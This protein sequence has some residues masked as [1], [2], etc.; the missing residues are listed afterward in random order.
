MDVSYNNKTTFSYYNSVV[1]RLK[2]FCKPLDHNFGIPYSL[3]YK[4]YNDSRY[5]HLSNDLNC[6]KDY[7]TH[8]LY[9]RLY[10]REYLVNKCSYT[11]ILWPHMPETDSMK[12]FV[13]HG[14]WHGISLVEQDENSLTL[15]D[16]LGHKDNPAIN[17]TFIRNSHYLGYF[18]DLFK[19]RFYDVI[20]AVDKQPL[21]YENGSQFVLPTNENPFNSKINEF[22][23][24]TGID[25]H[26]IRI[27]E[28]MI[29][30]SPQQ[31]DCLRLLVQGYTLKEIAWRKSMAVT[32]VETHIK[33][34]KEK[35]GIYYNSDLIRLTKNQ[36]LF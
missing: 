10:F 11:Q 9:E 17:E 7:A 29:H 16:F 31:Y 24:E 34:I 33:R 1:Y 23:Q 25:I 36:I 5:I 3:Y 6:S 32:T 28:K 35:A 2:E 18:V 4:V 20:A 19:E 22:I 14:Y 12:I 15:Y 13:K 21:I 8:C 30:L 26:S 27:N